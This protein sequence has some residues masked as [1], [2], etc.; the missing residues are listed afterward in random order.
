MVLVHSEK[1]HLPETSSG[2]TQASTD[3]AAR[4]HHPTLSSAETLVVASDFL[5]HVIIPLCTHMP[6]QSH[7]DGVPTK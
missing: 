1:Q 5:L 3:E 2:L 6:P 7:R 4:S